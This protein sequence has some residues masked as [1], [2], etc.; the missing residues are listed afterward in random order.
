MPMQV[1]LG[2]LTVLM[3]MAWLAHRAWGQD[4]QRP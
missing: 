2:V 3:L 4:S 1:L